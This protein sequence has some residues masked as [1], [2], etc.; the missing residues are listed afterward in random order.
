MNTITKTVRDKINE[1]YHKFFI[2]NPGDIPD[3]LVLDRESYSLLKESM[4]IPAYEDIADFQGF[5]I[6]IK[7]LEKNY[8]RFI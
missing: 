4:D 7:P 3:Y 5:I 8:V 6:H 2:D 1:E